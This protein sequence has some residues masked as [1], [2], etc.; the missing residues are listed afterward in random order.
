M[1]RANEGNLIVDGTITTSKI[2]AGAITTTLLGAQAV[3]A[4]KLYL[5]D[6][7]NM[8]LDT[9]FTDLTFWGAMAGGITVNT[10]DTTQL[11]AMHATA[12]LKS[13]TGNGTTSLP[14]SSVV[15]LQIPCEAGKTYRFAFDWWAKSGYTG[16]CTFQIDWYDYSHTAIGTSQFINGIDGRS[17]PVSGDQT[18]NRDAQLVAPTNAAYVR[19]R[20]AFFWSTT[21]GSAQ[22]AY[23]A[24]PRI[25]RANEGNLIVDGSIVA[26]KIAAGTITADRMNVTTLSSIAANIGTITAGKL[27]NGSAS[28]V[29]DLTNSNVKVVAGSYVKYEGVGF[30][31]SSD[32][33]MWFGPSSTAIGSC[34]K[35]NGIVA[36]ATDGKFYYPPP[37][38]QSGTVLFES[39]DPGTWSFTSPL[40]PTT[41]YLIFEFWAAGGSGGNASGSGGKVTTYGRGAGGGGY[42]KHKIALPASATTYTGSIGAGG[43]AGGDGGNTTCTT[44]SI[45][46]NGGTHGVGTT[47]NGTGGT[48]SGGNQTNTTG[49]AGGLTNTWDGGGT[50]P[51]NVDQTTTG[52][53]G[54]T[55]GGGG[56]GGG[57]AQGGFGA[58]GRV[59]I[60]AS[61]T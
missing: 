37:P 32:L 60:T 9:D 5:G 61:D 2:T 33:L 24:N 13:A 31:V 35:T 21:L 20:P 14:T 23:I 12:A 42:S 48:A 38:V 39:D 22:F 18:G 44:L 26:A 4:S 30:G 58:N 27:Q 10:T 53:T 8:L 15:S 51:A 7:S 59:K 49:R 1:N 54:T 19:L 25:N 29:I 50:A 45:T 3:T 11:A 40:P 41:S 55:P 47:T 34:T 17:V 46:C 57:Y 56:A 43:Q 16:T 52:G 28:Y 36:M 6:T